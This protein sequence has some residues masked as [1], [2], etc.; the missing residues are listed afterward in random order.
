MPVVQERIVR[1]IH[2]RLRRKNKVKVGYFLK[3]ERFEN[4]I[5]AAIISSVSN[6]GQ[7]KSTTSALMT[8]AE[9]MLLKLTSS[10]KN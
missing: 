1:K 8:T 3:L 6:A 9:S 7:T 10:F 4:T 2:S 5:S